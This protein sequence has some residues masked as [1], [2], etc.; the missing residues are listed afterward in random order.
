MDKYILNNKG[1]ENKISK[2]GLKKYDKV[3]FTY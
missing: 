1:L 2:L 3:N